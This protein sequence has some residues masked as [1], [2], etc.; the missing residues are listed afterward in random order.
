MISQDYQVPLKTHLSARAYLLLSL[1]VTV[2][3][4]C[5]DMRLESLAEALPLPILFE[6]RRKKSNG[7]SHS[8]P[9][10]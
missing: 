8:V 5:R 6:S 4:T 7:S 3:Q 2:V 9:S 10:V 1:L